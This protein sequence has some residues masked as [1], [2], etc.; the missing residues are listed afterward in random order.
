[1]VPAEDHGGSFQLLLRLGKA[2]IVI[3]VLAVTTILSLGVGPSIQQI[4]ETRTTEAIV[5]NATAEVAYTT[6]YTSK[7]SQQMSSEDKAIQNAQGVPRSGAHYDF[8]SALA[9]GVVDPLQPSFECPGERC[10]WPEFTTLGICTKVENI[11]CDT[12]RE[13]GP[14]WQQNHY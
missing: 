8:L 1:M 10:S 4:L 13:C 6:N 14:I 7:A 3:S 11:T 5:A 12:T 2:N 9:R